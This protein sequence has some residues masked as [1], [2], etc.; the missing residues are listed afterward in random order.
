[1]KFLWKKSQ[2]RTRAL[3]LFG[4]VLLTAMAFRVM[5]E[6]AFLAQ[7]SIAGAFSTLTPEQS[8]GTVTMTARYLPPPYGFSE[9]KLLNYFAKE[10]NLTI[11][12]EIREVTYEGR[13][14]FVYEKAAAEADSIVK[15]V[16][17]TEAG[18]YYLC[19]EITL[20]GKNAALVSSFRDTLEKVAKKMKMEEIT[21]A[22]ELCGSYTGEIPLAR[23]DEL[24]NRLLEE[25]Y[26]QPVYENRENKN[27]TVYAYTGAVKDYIVVEQ[28][29]INVQVA[30]YYDR[31]TDRTEVVLAS[32]IGLR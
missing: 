20:Y 26:A 25:L 5:T 16:Y 2:K 18:E 4:S 13:V 17:L 21:T 23:K 27:Y 22:L 3:I 24:T 8:K 28:K 11:A 32:P 7:A 12:G 19:A 30:I 10:I 9:E 29:K 15:L 6:R 14:E 1:M 31:E